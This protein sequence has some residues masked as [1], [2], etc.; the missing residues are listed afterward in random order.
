MAGFFMEQVTLRALLEAGCH[1]GHKA[2]RWHPKAHTFIYQKREG[3]HIIDL[4][5]TKAGLEA[6]A[7]FIKNEAASG[8]TVL[9]IGTKRQASAILKDEAEKAGAAYM[10]KRWVGGF[11]TNWETVHKNLE[12]IRRLKD[13]ELNGTWK[14]YPKHERVK[15]GRY[16]HKLE[17]FYGGVLTLNELPS[18]IFVVDIKREEV[19][20]NEA[21]KMGIP[22]VAVVDTNTDPTPVNWQIPANDDAVGSIKFIVT[23]IS[24]A[25]REGKD[26]FEKEQANE[27]AKTKAVE[28][29]ASEKIAEKASEVKKELPK[30]ETKPAE[31]NLAEKPKKRGRPKKGK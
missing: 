26:Q 30:V 8:R 15:L 28:V 24:E 4:A 11:L 29:K 19:A 3:I 9:F 2:D 13:E 10:N 21:V 18:S 31:T 1:F 16:V 17:Q 6:A 25:Y 12:K 27:L 14:K 5:K 23:Y 20:V 22:I 7:G